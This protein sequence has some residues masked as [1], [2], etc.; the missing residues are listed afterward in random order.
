MYSFSLKDPRGF[1]NVTCP[2]LSSSSS[3]TSIIV[4]IVI[5]VI[6]GGISI[7]LI[8]VLII[9]YQ[10]F[11]KA[12]PSEETS[13]ES[14]FDFSNKTAMMADG[15]RKGSKTQSVSDSEKGTAEVEN[16]KELTPPKE[17]DE[18]TL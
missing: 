8:V 14:A 2:R 5:G 9:Y 11:R 1:F 15:K 7:S 16:Q 3:Q 13:R 4:A 18:T 12:D 6:I 17:K 10:F